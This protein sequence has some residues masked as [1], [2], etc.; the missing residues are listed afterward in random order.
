MEFLLFCSHVQY[1]PEVL[2]DDQVFENIMRIQYME[3]IIFPF[4]LIQ[5][6][7]ERNQFSDYALLADNG[8]NAPGTE[9]STASDNDISH[10]IVHSKQNWRRLFPPSPYNKGLNMALL[11]PSCSNCK[12]DED[13]FPVVC[14]NF[15]LYEGH[16][17]LS[18]GFGWNAPEH[19]LSLLHLVQK[20]TNSSAHG[21]QILQNLCG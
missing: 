15:A 21:R 18:N 8:S 11:L 20:S 2:M 4:Q 10:Q 12:P 1:R 17:Q 6:W 13:L 16:L 7:I 3:I 19:G 9:Y 5:T 14:N